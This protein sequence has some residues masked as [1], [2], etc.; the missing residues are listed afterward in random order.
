[1]SQALSLAYLCHQPFLFCFAQ[2]TVT[3]AVKTLV[4][5]STAGGESKEVRI[6]SHSKR[7]YGPDASMAASFYTGTG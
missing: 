7:K 1:M 6:G 3:F 5:M 2:F 4:T